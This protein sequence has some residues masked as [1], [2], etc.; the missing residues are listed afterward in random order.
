MSAQIGGAHLGIVEK[1]TALALKGDAAGFQH[2]G[3]VG[4]AERLIGHLL[5]QQDRQSRLAQ[6]RGSC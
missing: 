4:D 5:D 3:A 1:V 6:A 2:I